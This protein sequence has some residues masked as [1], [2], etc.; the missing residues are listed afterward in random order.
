MLDGK[1]KDDL[2]AGQATVPPDS[3]VRMPKQ[4]AGLTGEGYLGNGV[5]LEGMLDPEQQP[6]RSN[7]KPRDVDVFD[8]GPEERIPV[9][10]RIE[11][12][13]PA[14]HAVDEKL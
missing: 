7:G 11:A 4:G 9:S 13:L 10:R 5:M 6:P 8:F 3:H 1:M 12:L 2:A 14:I